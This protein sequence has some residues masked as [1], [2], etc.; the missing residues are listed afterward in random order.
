[1]TAA[2][3][4]RKLQGLIG[5]Q[6][7]YIGEIWILIEILADM[8]SV[9]IRRCRDCGQQGVQQN[10]YGMPNRRAGDT[11]TLPI[12]DARGDAYSEDLLLLLE[13]R[14]SG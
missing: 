2:T 10:L 8:D 11:L 4:H 3:L 6:F 9:V 1:M 7:D 14:R 13:G 12:S 5:Q